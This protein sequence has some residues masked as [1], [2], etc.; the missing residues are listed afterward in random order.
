MKKNILLKSLILKNTK[1]IFDAVKK[2][3]SS[4]IKTI[5][6]VNEKQK[7]LGTVSDGDIRRALI[8]KINLKTEIKKILTKK[9]VTLNSHYDPE[10]AFELMKKKQ[11]EVAPI[12]NDKKEIIDYITA[13]DKKYSKINNYLIIMAG[14]KGKR[15]MPLTKKIPKPMLL[16]E[17]KPILQHLINNAKSEGIKNILISINHLGNVIKKY[18]KDGS[19][20]NLNI[21]Y[22]NEK[23]P[24]GTCGSISLCKNKIRNDFIVC[25]GDIITNIKFSE[26]L[27]FH[28]KTN[29]DVTVAI[30][31]YEIQNPY[32]VVKI[33]NKKLI[34]IV[35]K[36]FTTS[37]INV[38]AYV[39]K[40][41]ITKFLKKN[42]K[43]D[44]TDFLLL[45]KKKKK[46]IFACPLYEQWFDI[47]R[48]KDLKY[49]QN[50]KK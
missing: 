10:Q 9:N 15:L 20:M 46:K 3:N 44:M 33:K 1:S 28:K 8:R 16:I 30:K 45:L 14:G 38:G 7:F 25:N 40:P 23:F 27:N 41:N 5:F 2:I 37:F 17:N 22:I 42:K 39:F 35:E 34:D 48:P 18:F 12:L 32:G 6:V 13:K 43:I 31:S 29:A 50:L 19:K 4:K 49:I 21:E 36:P 24:L 47:G 26:L 11:I